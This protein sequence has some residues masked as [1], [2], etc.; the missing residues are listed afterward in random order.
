MAGYYRADD[1]NTGNS[2][3]YL[4]K[5]A[6]NLLRPRLE[7]AFE[8]DEITFSQWCAL[9]C[10][11]DRVARNSAELSRALNYDSGSLTR[12]IDNL[13]ERDLLRRKRHATDRRVQE[14]ALTAS[15]RAMAHALA[16][17][18]MGLLNESLTGFSR[19]DA[20]HLLA[21]LRRFVTN[22]QG[23]GTAPQKGVPAKRFR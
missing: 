14:L 23:C 3:G 4:V 19:R 5:Q 20:D 1:F 18:V 17:R 6:H 21:L 12:L 16:P 8:E 9:V 15:G 22:L 10:L 7:A 13:E 11:R 2:V